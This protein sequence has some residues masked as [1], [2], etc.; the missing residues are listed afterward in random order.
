MGRCK[1]GAEA[2]DDHG[3]VQGDQQ[4]LHEA[5]GRGREC[6]TRVCCSGCC[7]CD[8]YGF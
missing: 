1:E 7:C 3:I 6:A 2:S 8:C 5:G 4:L